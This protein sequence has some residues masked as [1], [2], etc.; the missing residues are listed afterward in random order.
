M[1]LKEIAF[2]M[3]EEGH[4]VTLRQ[5]PDGTLELTAARRPGPQLSKKPAPIADPSPARHKR[6]K[7]RGKGVIMTPDDLEEIKQLRKSGMTI[8]TISERTG[9]SAST[10]GRRLR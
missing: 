6:S 5:E 1:D 8:P 9:W 2:D 4:V 10:I 7:G 3:L